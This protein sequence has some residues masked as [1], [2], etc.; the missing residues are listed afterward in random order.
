VSPRYSSIEHL[1]RSLWLGRFKWTNQM[2]MYTAYLDDSGHPDSGKYL[3]VAGAIADIRQW[4]HLEREWLE[5]L[6]PLG[7]EVFHATDFADRRPP[8]DRLGESEREKFLMSLVYII[9]RR[10]ERTISGAVN[11]E[12]HR[13]IDSGYVFSARSRHELQM[14]NYSIRGQAG[15]D[16]PL[17]AKATSNRAE[18]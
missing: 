6:E 9:R 3:V 18:A 5:V 15:S 8:Y 13:A 11:L 12:H 1:A 14:P 10:V 17:L 2:A 4:V 16:S 7:T